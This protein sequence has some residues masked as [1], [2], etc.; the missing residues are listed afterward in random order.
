MFLSIP[1]LHVVLPGDLN[2]C[3]DPLRTAR[4]EVGVVQVARGNCG[5]PIG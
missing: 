4:N 5:D 2:R 1:A 3:F